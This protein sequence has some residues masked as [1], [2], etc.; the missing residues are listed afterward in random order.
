MSYDSRVIDK[1]NHL[2]RNNGLMEK[3]W[4]RYGLA[5]YKRWLTERSDLPDLGLKTNYYNEDG[6]RLPQ[7]SLAKKWQSKNRGKIMGIKDFMRKL[8]GHDI[9][10][11]NLASFIGVALV[12][13]PP[14]VEVKEVKPVVIETKEKRVSPVKIKEEAILPNLELDS[15]E[16]F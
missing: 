1:I 12:F 7:V 6:N 9:S 14:K 11:D 3:K 2:I 13:F 8:E 4:N 15:W 16:D 10:L 5:K